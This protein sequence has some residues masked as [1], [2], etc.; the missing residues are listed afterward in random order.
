MAGIKVVSSFFWRP[1]PL[2]ER[3]QRRISWRRSLR[4]PDHRQQ[5]FTGRVP[6]DNPITPSGL[7]AT[8][9]TLLGIDPAQELHPAMGAQCVSQRTE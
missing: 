3:F 2:A 7:A 8:V 4:R 5:R 9:Y 1:R 6:Q